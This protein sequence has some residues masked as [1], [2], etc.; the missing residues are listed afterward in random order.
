MR[1]PDAERNP[2]RRGKIPADARAWGEPAA[3]RRANRTR[4]DFGN[5]EAEGARCLRRELCAARD[6]VYAADGR[7]GFPRAR[8]KGGSRSVDMQQQNGGRA[9]TTITST[10][11]E[12]L[13]GRRMLSGGGEG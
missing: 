3:A 13:E 11:V 1:S 7:A 4:A 10:G 9:S 5:F 6:G 12:A 2:D 8:F